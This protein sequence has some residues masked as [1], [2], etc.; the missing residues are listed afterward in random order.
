VLVSRFAIKSTL[1]GSYLVCHGFYDEWSSSIID[2]RK[3]EHKPEHLLAFFDHVKIKNNLGRL[4]Y[5][6]IYMDVCYNT[7]RSLVL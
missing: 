1:S 7:Y 5:E 4:R 6:Y 3:W 2:A